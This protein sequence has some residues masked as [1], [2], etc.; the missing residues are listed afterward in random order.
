M[1][2]SLLF[3]VFLLSCGCT[4]NG[5]GHVNKLPKDSTEI[6]VDSLVQPVLRAYAIPGMAI[7]VTIDGKRFYYNFGVASKNTSREITNQTLFEIGSISKTFTATLACYAQTAGFLSL[8]DPVSN[9]LPSLRKSSFDSIALI[10]LATHTAG[11]FPL[12]LPEQIKDSVQLMDYFKQWRPRFPVGSY[13]V[14]ANPGIGLLGVIAARSMHRPFTDLIEKTTFPGLGLTNSYIDVPLE[15]MAEYAQGYNDADSP[16]RVSKGVLAPE[17]YGIKSCTKDLLQYAEVNMG[18][19]KVNEPWRQAV[20]DTHSGY[21]RCG[22]LT[23][24]LIWEQYP[25][26]TDSAML[27]AGNAT[28]MILEPNPVTRIAP[29]LPPQ[30]QVLIDKTGST[31][32]FGAYILFI[33]AKKTGVVILA[34]KSYPI[35][36]RVRLAYQLLKR[37]E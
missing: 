27:L 22:V 21:Y 20:M 35:D 17:T 8:K 19:A 13:R 9:Y 28:S 24:D 34:N 4:G 3:F 26:P 1:R 11:G 6:A 10:D 12:Q 37:F 5:N 16:V 18:I 36:G 7:G 15:K 23:Q 29:E 31:N 2:L 25:Y 33:P 30:Q 14:Y 32:G